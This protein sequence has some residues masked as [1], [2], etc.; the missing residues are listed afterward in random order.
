MRGVNV[1]ESA[2]FTAAAAAISVTRRGAQSSL[3]S[4]EE[5]AELL[6]RS[7]GKAGCT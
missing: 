3:P 7:I 5:V 1:K 2:Q 4:Q 6:E